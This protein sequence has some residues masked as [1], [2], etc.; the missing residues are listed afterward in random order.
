MRNPS[1]THPFALKC[2]VWRAELDDQT[3]CWFSADVMLRFTLLFT[4]G[5]PQGKLHHYT[6]VSSLFIISRCMTSPERKEKSGLFS[7]CFSGSTSVRLYCPVSTAF[8]CTSAGGF[9]AVLIGAATLVSY[10]TRTE[11]G[12][13]KVCPAVS[14]CMFQLQTLCW[15]CICIL[16]PAS[17]AII[18][19]FIHHTCKAEHLLE[20]REKC[21]PL[22][23]CILYPESCFSVLW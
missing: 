6:S 11:Y 2:S 23:M 15:I 21:L 18:W 1:P 17:L 12:R 7:K 9:Y 4:P 19:F 22:L 14:S 3:F 13:L 20:R 10:L 8:A 5:G 16:I